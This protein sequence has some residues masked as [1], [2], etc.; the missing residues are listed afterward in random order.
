MAPTKK[1]T[2][3]AARNASGSASS[4]GGA[5][6]A[7]GAGSKRGTAGE[8]TILS[9][10]ALN[11]A[12]LARQMLLRREA[13]KP[14]AAIE[15]LLALQAQLARPPFIALW[16]RLADFRRQDLIAAIDKRVLVRATMMRAT[17]H[18][19][20]RH[21]FIAF[22]PVIQPVL[23]LAHQ[24]ILKD[25]AKGIEIEKLLAAARA[26]FDENACTL[27]EL[28]KHLVSGPF[29]KLDE[30]AMGYIVKMQLPLVQL[31][32]AG[33]MWAYPAAANFAV[34][35]SWLDEPLTL[36]SDK[37]TAPSPQAFAL[38]YFAAFGPASVQDFQS[39]AG[40]KTM[41][42]VIEELRPKLQTFRDQGGRELFDLPKAPRPSGDEEAPVRFL[43]E[44]D[45]VILG[46]ADRDRIIDAA[47]KPALLTKNL[48]VPATF[49][50]DGF[51]AGRWTLDTKKGIARLG[52]KPFGALT[53][54]ARTAL[55]EE[56]EQLLRFV[57]PDAKSHVVDIEKPA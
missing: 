29:S 51:I 25:R 55:S 24:A 5:P 50:V 57:E 2:T 44:F 41:R 52:L 11:R 12:M 32:E 54:A 18:L 8:A 46:Y 14:V 48:L 40:F 56:G 10:R 39:W 13:I 16:S 20:T 27:D 34:A 28:R 6:S 4:A 49:L 30:R 43:P 17:I 21:D 53:K 26:F 45:N 19:L 31:P 9:R 3:K 22:R 23:T 38:R 15:R 42:A 37:E 36:A 33:A 35:E 7:R 1:A 47:H